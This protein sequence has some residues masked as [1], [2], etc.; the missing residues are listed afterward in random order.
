MVTP[1]D[2]GELVSSAALSPA[3]PVLCTGSAPSAGVRELGRILDIFVRHGAQTLPIVGQ[4]GEKRRKRN[5]KVE[6]NGFTSRKRAIVDAWL[7]QAT[8]TG[9]WTR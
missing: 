1:A 2:S 4:I 7:P 6:L 3:G 8:W 5:A 9:Y